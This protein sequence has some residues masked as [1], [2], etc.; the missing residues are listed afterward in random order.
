ML[1]E[2]PEDRYVIAPRTPV[3]GDCP[4]CGAPSLQA[5]R[6]LAERGWRGV[7]K[8]R[9]CLTEVSSEADPVGPIDLL[10]RHV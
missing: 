9:A 2:R 7:V 6:V 3:D 8:C 1:Y 4:G 5:Y 10:S